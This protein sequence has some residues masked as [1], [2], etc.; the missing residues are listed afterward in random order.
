MAEPVAARVLLWGQT[1]GAVAE[2][3]SGQVV[4][5]YD[6]GFRRSGLEI[7]PRH[8][9]LAHAGPIAFPELRRLESFMGLPGVLADALPDRFGTEVIRQYFT[10]ARSPELADRPIQRLLYVGGRAMGALEFAPPLELG[11]AEEEI[12]VLRDLVDQSRAVVEGRTDVAIR[13]ILQLGSSAGGARPKALVLWNRETDE[14]RSA[15]AAPR[16]GDEAWIIKFDGV[17]EVRAPNAAPQPFNRIELACTRMAREAG[18]TTAEV[19]PLVDGEYRHLLSRRFD[20]TAAGRLHYHSL[21][22]L[23]HA[24]YNTPGSYSY[25]RYLLVCRELG[26]T[27]GELDEAYARVVFNLLAVN[28]DDHVKN[29]GFL[30]DRQGRWSLAPAFDLTFAKGSGFTRRHQLSLAGKTDRFTLQDLLA[31]GESLGLRRKGAEKIERC[32]DALADWPRFAREAQVPAAEVRRIGAEHR[33][34]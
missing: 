28:Q 10:R 6:P 13:E 12:L 26:L 20:R 1:V 24:D 33:R 21:G 4:F 18:I 9:P 15:H 29:F 22:G 19:V 32:R 31:L 27:P 11:P 17:G 25:E 2:D 5:E 8:L 23:D 30:M 7:S 14:L 34:L 3:P 16:P